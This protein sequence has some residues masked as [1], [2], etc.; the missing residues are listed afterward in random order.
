MIGTDPVLRESDPREVLEI[1]NAIART[2]PEI[3]TNMPALRLL[4]REAVSYEGLT[5]DSQKQLTD[6]RQNSSKAESQESDNL[7]RRYS[8]GGGIKSK[9]N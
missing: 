2:N 9:S 6:I 5:L 7:K 1:Y 3:V 4:L 8:I